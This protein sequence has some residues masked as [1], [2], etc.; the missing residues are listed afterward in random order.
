MTGGIHYKTGEDIAIMREAGRIVANAHGELRAALRPGVT[1]AQLNDL[2]ETVLRDHG[3]QPVFLGYPKENAP[4]FPASICASVNEELVHGIPGPRALQAGDI[5]SVDIGARYQGFV[6]D[7]AWTYAVDEVPPAV[8]RLLDVSE[9]ALWVGIRAAVMPAETRDVAQ[10]IQRFVE[11]KGYSVVRE[12]T[13]HGVG[14]SMHEEPQVPNWWPRRR[15]QQPR[16]E[17]VPLCPGMTIALE[18]MVNSGLAETEELEDQWTVVTRDGSL[19]TH[20]EHS[21]AITEGEPLVLTLP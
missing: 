19:C 6:G 13:G 21:I 10:A 18:P 2:V 4:D 11:R 16:W 17:S 5:I 15:R 12:Y 8:Q 1:T 14:R 7:A 9:E 20:F 3:A